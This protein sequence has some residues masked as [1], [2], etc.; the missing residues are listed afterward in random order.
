MS[1]TTANPAHLGLDLVSLDLPAWKKTIG[2]VCALLLAILFF[3]SGAWKL[4]DPFRWSQ[5]LEEFH[6]PGTLALPGALALGIAE[7]VGAVLVLVPRFRRWGAVLL[8]LLLV[9]FMVYIGANYGT[10]VG[11][12]CTCFPL[13]K[14]AVNP[15]FFL[16]DGSFLLMAVLA[17][18]WARTSESLRGAL[19]ILGAVVVFAGVSFGVN[20]ARESGLKAPASITV[21]GKPVSLQ[22][23]NTFLFFYDPTCPHC[24]A[25]ARKMAK[26]NWK[27]AKIVAIPIDTPQ[28][29]AS[30]LH[31]TGLKAGTSNDLDL[32]KGTFKFATAPYG[33]ALVRGHQKA[34]VDVGL[35]ETDG[36][37][38]ATLHGLGFVE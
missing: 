3:T 7:M 5:M 37:P 25:A 18:L 17:G 15:A 2:G 29:A 11:K 12:D 27:D 26:L 8:G 33:V 35:F 1:D 24:E 32:L 36:Q 20:S 19:V 31:D 28:F 14:R 30:F 34:T 16:E 6:V 21:D 13:V 38:A 4:T 23:G 10:L 22:D 9:V